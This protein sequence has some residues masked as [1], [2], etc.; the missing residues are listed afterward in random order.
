M[1]ECPYCGEVLPPKEG[2]SVFLK[3]KFC[4][5][6]SIDGSQFTEPQLKEFEKGNIY[7]WVVK[8][9]PK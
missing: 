7:P 3:C 6:L 2:D 8:E 9:V 1:N 5:W 4:Q